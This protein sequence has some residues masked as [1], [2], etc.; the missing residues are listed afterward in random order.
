M[1]TI[2]NPL[3]ERERTEKTKNF[4]GDFDKF[5]IAFFI[6]IMVLLFVDIKV[7]FSTPWDDYSFLPSSNKF[8]P[9]K[10]ILAVVAVLIAGYSLYRELSGDSFIRKKIKK[11]GTATLAFGDQKTI[12]TQIFRNQNGQLFAKLPIQIKACEDEGSYEICEFDAIIEAKESNQP[13]K[14]CMDRMC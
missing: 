11:L 10:L 12:K 2:E 7:S 5:K 4:K 13:I 1:T 8:S 6:H 3:I 14:E 9:K